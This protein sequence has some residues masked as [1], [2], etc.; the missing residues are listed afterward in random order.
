MVE[1]S[2]ADSYAR[3]MKKYNPLSPD[4]YKS[5]IFNLPNI[6]MIVDDAVR[7]G[8]DVCEGSIGWLSKESGVEILSLYDEAVEFSGIQFVSAVTCNAPYYVDSFNRNRF[9]RTDCIFTKHTRNGW[10]S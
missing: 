4:Q 2:K 5:D 8:I 7:R 3:R 1:K 9:I 10:Q 6:I